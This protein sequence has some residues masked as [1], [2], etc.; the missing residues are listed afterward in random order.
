MRRRY[1]TTAAMTALTE[2][3]AGHD[4]VILQHV[5]TLRFVT[6]SQ[7]TRLCF[8][9]GPDPAANARAA[10]R[11]LLRLTRL[12]VLERL[13]RAIG[14]VRAGSAGFVYHLSPSGQRLAVKHGLLP[15]WHRR[16]SRVPGNLFVAH[17]LQVAEL[18][19]R[20]VER[21]RSRR[22][23][24]LELRAEPLCHR[25]YDGLGTPAP[26]L[27]PD[28]FLRLGLGDYEYSFFIEVDRGTEGSQAIE[29]QLDA[30]VAYYLSGAEQATRGVFPKV[31]WLTPS[32]ERASAIAD[33]VQR[34]PANGRA[35]F[36]VA[37]F[38]QALDVMLELI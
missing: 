7:L 18:H 30:Y 3:L 26:V 20:L 32:H 1:L 14:G 2:R 35:I 27:K 12:G 34:L 36:Q 10:R 5:S 25:T 8:T 29:R 38:D 23:E 37:T 31:L 15:E 33:S 22:F 11:A 16:R 21:E 28:S 19:T 24:L 13:P 4:L 9:A 6:G 17:T